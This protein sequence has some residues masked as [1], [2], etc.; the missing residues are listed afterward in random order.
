MALDPSSS[1]RLLL[2][3]GRE[4]PALLTVSTQTLLLGSRQRNVWADNWEKEGRG[5]KASSILTET[6]HAEESRQDGGGGGGGLPLRFPE[7]GGWVSTNLVPEP[8]IARKV[9]SALEM[10]KPGPGLLAL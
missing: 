7:A 5:R 3:R 9:L 2:L 8:A 1:A 4:T 6:L 10:L